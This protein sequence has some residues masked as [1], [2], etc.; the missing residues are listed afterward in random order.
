MTCAPSRMLLAAPG[1]S[2]RLPA[3]KTPP[4]VGYVR[5]RCSWTA[6]KSVAWKCSVSARPSSPTL[7]A[8]RT[9]R[10][11]DRGSNLKC[12]DIFGCE[13]V[14]IRF[15]PFAS[16]RDLS[17]GIHRHPQCK[18]TTN[19]Q[20][21]GRPHEHALRLHNIVLPSYYR[22]ANSVLLGTDGGLP[23]G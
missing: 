12:L 21:T 3:Q 1:I 7:P 13:W 10:S 9:M 8:I 14:S 22:T 19:P 17:P 6:Q 2:A 11:T 5:S 20:R 16:S 23:C 15:K 4:S 18:T